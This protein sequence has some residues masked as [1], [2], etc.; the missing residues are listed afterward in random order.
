[1]R[2]MLGTCLLLALV[3]CKTTAVTPAPAPAKPK[4]TTAVAGATPGP[5]GTP[6]APIFLQRPANTTSLSGKVQID[7]SYIIANHAASLVSNNGSQV[8]AAG[9]GIISE[10]GAGLVSNHGGG[11]LAT[12]SGNI[13]ANNA[14]ALVGKSKYSLAED[15]APAYGTQLPAAAMRV[16]VFDLSTG[17]AVPLG[18]DADGKPVEAVYTNLQGGFEVFLPKDLAGNVRLEVGVAESADPRLTYH[19]ITQPAATERTVDEDTATATRYMRQVFRDK[20]A[21]LIGGFDKFGAGQLNDQ[22][23]VDLLLTSNT[24]APAAQALLRTFILDLLQEVRANPQIQKADYSPLGLELGD[25]LLAQGGDFDGIDLI[26]AFYSGQSQID[27]INADPLHP[28][29]VME[30]FLG[31]CADERKAVT[32]LGKDK[33][34]D[35]VAALFA[36]KPYLA[37]ANKYHAR[38]HPQDPAPFYVIRKPSDFADFLAAEYFTMVDQQAYGCIE[39]DCPPPDPACL[40]GNLCFPERG[41]S[42]LPHAAEGTLQVNAFQDIGLPA[43]H[44]ELL[45]G[46]TQ[47]LFGNL[48]A[49]TFDPAVNARMHCLIRSY[50]RPEATCDSP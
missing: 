30:A 14:G 1:M 2:R 50:K 40:V 5:T 44:V 32:A 43:N 16:R 9:D 10:H 47:S 36:V 28:K 25:A 7:A 29:R 26:P 42:S 12:A 22:Q 35:Q 31:V 27:A 46:A 45:A 17:K 37:A 23:L 6:A 49:K 15:T 48:I 13:I 34:P 3:A 19:V 18:A 41:T 21:N 24:M 39:P 8:L 11:V 38:L 20:F 4:A 33:T